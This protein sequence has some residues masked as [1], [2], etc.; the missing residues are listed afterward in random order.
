MVRVG[1][2]LLDTETQRTQRL[3]REIQIK[4]PPMLAEAA[5]KA[6]DLA[7]LKSPAWYEEHFNLQAKLFNNLAQLAAGAQQELLIRK[8]GA[9]SESQLQTWTDNLKRLQKEDDEFRKQIASIESRQGVVLI[10]E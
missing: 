4:T 5:T 7:K 6:K 9:P 1:Q 3:H 8:N 10:K 2:Q